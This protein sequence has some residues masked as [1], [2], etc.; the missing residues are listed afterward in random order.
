MHAYLA[1]DIYN[2]AEA[3]E[4]ERIEVVLLAIPEWEEE[5]RRR[6]DPGQQEHRR[7]APG[8]AASTRPAVTMIDLRS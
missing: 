1:R 5:I 4:D 8:P 6:R 3:D 7:L 2:A